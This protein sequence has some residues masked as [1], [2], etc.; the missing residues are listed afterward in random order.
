VKSFST[1]AIIPARAGSKRLPGKNIKPLLGK[2]LIAWTVEQACRCQYFTDVVLSTDCENIAAVGKEYGAK[3]PFLRP[4]A[5]SQDHSSSYDL[6]EHALAYF[7]Q[8]GKNYDYVALL[9]PTS[10]LRKKQ[11]LDHAM[12]GFLE[13]QDQYDALISVGRIERE[14]PSI[15]KAITAEKKLSR[16]YEKDIKT[17]AYFPYGVIYASKV[18]TLLE[19]R[20]FYQKNTLPYLIERWQ[21]FEI[22]DDV[23][24]YCTESVMQK[25]EHCL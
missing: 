20:T 9:E 3:V 18:S 6:I 1:L 16:F 8:Q 13:N 25:Y 14:H 5:L 12:Q 21:N 17:E 11:D 19:T 7:N 22:D 10:P 4:P 23:D 2:P 24:F 15:I